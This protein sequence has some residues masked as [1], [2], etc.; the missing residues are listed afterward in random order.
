M[1]RF[2]QYRWF[3]LAA[4]ITLAFAAVSLTVPRGPALTAISD[5]GSLLL[6]LAVA[7][8]MLANAWLSAGLTGGF[9]R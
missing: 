5:I 4:A 8:A 7:G 6:Y 1:T 3:V 9:G 2:G